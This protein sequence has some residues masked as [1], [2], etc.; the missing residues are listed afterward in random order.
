[1]FCES[2]GII[3]HLTASYS[4]QQNGVVERRNRT[5]MGMIRSILRGMECPNYLWGEAIRHSTYI[6]NRVAARVLEFKT[7]YEALK[8]KKPNVSH[9]RI[10]GCI[11]YAKVEAPHLKKLESQSRMLV[12]RR[13]EPGSKSYRLYD[14]TSRKIIVS[15]D[16]IF[17]E[18][19]MWN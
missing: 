12:Q 10:F 13:T 9:I 16:V 8:E 17:D 15:G 18:R 7:P 6:I 1:M 3:R 2:T 11:A 19:K 14:P 5:L 4:P